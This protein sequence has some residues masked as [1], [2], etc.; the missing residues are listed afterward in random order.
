METFTPEKKLQLNPHFEQQKKQALNGLDIALVDHPLRGLSLG[1]NDLPFCFTL[2]CCYGHFVY[3]GQ[4]DSHNLTALSARKVPGDV[5]YR[6]AYLALGVADTP[7]GQELRAR[8]AEIKTI[9]PDN[10][11]FGCAEWFWRRQINSYVLQVTPDR[12]KYCDRA[13]LNLQEALHIE[14]VRNLFFAQLFKVLESM[15]EMKSKPP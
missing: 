7:A 12:F 3:P 15:R 1:L 9:D 2:Q 4:D 14:R 6:L 13:M 8:L 10:I 11:Q 5:Q